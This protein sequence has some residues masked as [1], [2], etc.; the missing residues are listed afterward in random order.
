MPGYTIRT[1]SAIWKDMPTLPAPKRSSWFWL[2]LIG[3][4]VLV[5]FAV[6][7]FKRHFDVYVTQVVLFGGVFTLWALLRLVWGLFEKSVDLD[8]EDFSR[9]LL[10]SPGTTRLLAV[11]GLTVLALWYT[12]SSLY[13]E[14]DGVKEATFKIQVLEAGTGN[15]FMKP[16]EINAGTPVAGMP[17][18]LMFHDVAL[19]CRIEA[20]IGFE[21]AD[22]SMTR[23]QTTHLRVPR[24]FK[25]REFHLVRLVPIGQ[26]FRKLTP[27]EQGEPSHVEITVEVRRPGVPTPLATQQII[28]LRRETLYLLP[29]NIEE[30]SLVR[31]MEDGRAYR[32][33]IVAK[34]VADSTEENNARQTAEVLAEH[35]RDCP[36]TLLL[37]G[38][39]ILISIVKPAAENQPEQRSTLKHVVTADKVQTAWLSLSS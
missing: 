13:F 31:G 23:G 35:F 17:R 11:A 36:L 12:T 18:L 22:C 29:T 33:A 14:A 3:V 25:E 30:G 9:R 27:R 20:P 4:L 10:S 16:V 38:D 19:R 2:N 15:A 26:L 28:D 5:P 24:G 32:S 21:P 1:H 37:Q 7:L 6:V 34:L 8:Q 39:E